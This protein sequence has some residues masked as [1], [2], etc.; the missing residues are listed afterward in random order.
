MLITFCD[1]FVQDK[2]LPGNENGKLYQWKDIIFYMEFSHFS[3]HVKYKVKE[4][5]AYY[6]EDN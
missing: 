6:R 3:F 5:T 4:I 2:I 1:I